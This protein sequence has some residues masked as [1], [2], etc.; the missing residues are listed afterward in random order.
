VGRKYTW[1][2][3]QDTLTMSCID[4]AFCTTQWEEIYNNS[5]LQSLA[6]S[7]LDHCLILLM[8]L[9]SPRTKPK[10]RFESFW[11]LMLGYQECVSQA[12]NRE[13]PP[14]LNH[15]ATLHVKLS[16][17]ANALR[18][19]STSLLP[20]SKVPMAVCREVA[21]QLERAQEKRR[22]TV[23]EK[24]LLKTLKSSVLGMAAIEKRRAK[25]KS[26]LT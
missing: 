19:C 2:N 25:Q 10:F 26:R 6:S 5:I 7:S 22:L 12:W 9:I 13:A 3:Q 4:K 24:N 1:S 14:N 18:K 15:M 8:P 23:G 11:V 21:D 20:Q 16:R 17:A